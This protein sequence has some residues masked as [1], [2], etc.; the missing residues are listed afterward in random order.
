M[1][2]FLRHDVNSP[3]CC[4]TRFSNFDGKETNSSNRVRFF[5]QGGFVPN[6]DS[7]PAKKNYPPSLP[8]FSWR[9]AHGKTDKCIVLARHS[10]DFAPNRISTKAILSKYTCPTICL[11][12][13]I[14]K[15]YPRN[16]S[17]LPSSQSTRRKI[18]THKVPTKA[19]PTSSTLASKNCRI[20]KT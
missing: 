14:I 16:Q 4:T 6:F 9:S 15:H 18:C 17:S 2:I 5:G 10:R 8:A 7:K 11:D 3:I 19:P 12:N 13:L 20:C 1:V